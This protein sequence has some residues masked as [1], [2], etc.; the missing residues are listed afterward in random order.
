MLICTSG[1]DG[2]GS[3]VN[4]RA[5]LEWPTS[6]GGLVTTI[7]PDISGTS[8]TDIDFLIGMHLIQCTD[9]IFAAE[10]LTKKEFF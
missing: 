2:P 9:K 8:S 5:P 4:R 10:Q 7:Y 3:S 6:G 1:N